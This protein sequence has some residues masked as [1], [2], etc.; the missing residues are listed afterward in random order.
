MLVDANDLLPSE[1]QP[2]TAKTADSTYH[3]LSNPQESPTGSICVDGCE[4]RCFRLAPA[5]SFS[6][7]AFS[8][9]NICIPSSIE[10][11]SKFCFSRC[12]NLLRVTFES[13]C[14]IATFGESAFSYCS[15]LQSIFIPS[16][17]EGISKKCF[18][19]CEKLSQLTFESGS[20]MSKLGR[21]AFAYCYSLQWT[22]IPSSVRIISKEC[23]IECQTLSKLP[24]D[25]G[26]CISVL[27]PSAFSGCSLR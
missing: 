9:H 18:T 15:S 10:A 8:L 26:S 6:S 21:S 19:L 12:E 7:Q 2:T 16:S 11:I 22:C 20:Q 27:G 24:F 13:G 1:S 5:P 25:S 23:F 17:I 4:I 14:K 3:L